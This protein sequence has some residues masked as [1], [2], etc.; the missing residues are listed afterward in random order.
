MNPKKPATVRIA[1]AALRRRQERMLYP[2]LERPL[3][4]RQSRALAR[5]SAD[6]RNAG[7]TARMRANERLWHRFSRRLERIVGI[8]PQT[9]KL[10][11]MGGRP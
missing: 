11:G 3:T 9:P 8:G 1:A 2:L 7:G 10:A 6:R 5:W 4:T